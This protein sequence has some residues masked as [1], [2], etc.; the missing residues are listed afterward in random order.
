MAP[1]RVLWL[2][3]GLGLG[4][5]EH[6]LTRAL[7]HVDRARFEIDVAYVLPW[8]DA[9]VPAIEAQGVPVHCL[10]GGAAFDLR[11]VLRLRRLVAERKYDIVHTLM[12]YPA[13]AA[14]L[15]LHG[16]H[17]VHTEPNVWDAYRPFTAWANA[18]TYGSNDAVIAVSEAVAASVG[19]RRRVRRL[20]P[21]HTVVHGID[22]SG[23]RRGPDARAAARLTLGLKADDLVVGAVASLTPKKDHHTLLAA[24]AVGLAR[25]ADPTRLVLVGGGR[26]DAELR[27]VAGQLG[28]A[29]RV[30]FAGARDDVMALL[31]A[32]D[33]FA[34]SSRHEGLPIALVE[35]MATG[36]PAVA[37]TVGGVP[38]L[39]TDGEDGLLV[40]P[41]DTSAFAAAL[42]K[43]AADAPLRTAM[44][45]AAR[46][47]A[48]R[49]DL[50]GAMRRTQEIYDTVLAGE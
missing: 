6:R 27:A 37:T 46:A 45:D 50:S 32:F 39:I 43:L 38:E 48:G 29:D 35:A 17:L 41:G 7:R 40:P 26:L 19:V 13:I 24:F 3:K 49:L 33:I 23:I 10:R 4:G 42:A 25:G 9:L 2:A 5:T 28:I 16:V 30:V 18:A 20:P 11:W 15:A 22:H 8:K 36:L 31:P 34:L 14:R 12:P 1:R 47:R 44:G 21:V